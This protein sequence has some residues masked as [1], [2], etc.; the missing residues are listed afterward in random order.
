MQIS[1]WYIFILYCIKY[2]ILNFLFGLHQELLD[3]IWV[4]IKTEFL[5]LSEM[6]LN[7]FQLF[8][9]KYAKCSL[10][11]FSWYQPP[12]MV[13]TFC[14]FSNYEITKVLYLKKNAGSWKEDSEI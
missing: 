3:E 6:L 14:G 9:K 12:E 5:T 1:N 10:G 4:D 8:Y 7:I 2:L 13:P 11:P